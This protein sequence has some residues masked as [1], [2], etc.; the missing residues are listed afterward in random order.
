MSGPVIACNLF[1]NFYIKRPVVVRSMD[2]KDSLFK[3]DT[4][5]WRV[6]SPI[7]PIEA[8]PYQKKIGH[9]TTRYLKIVSPFEY[10]NFLTEETF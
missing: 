8:T 4:I 7:Q 9:I 3:K 2:K 6:E 1:T 10:Q 5:F